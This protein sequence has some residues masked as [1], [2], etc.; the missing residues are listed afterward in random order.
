[1]NQKPTHYCSTNKIFTVFS[2]AKK[3]EHVADGDHFYA[4]EQPVYHLI[5]CTI[6]QA[7]WGDG[8][9]PKI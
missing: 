4:V 9:Q 7:L 2:V 6:L 3:Q 8:K 5:L 1:M